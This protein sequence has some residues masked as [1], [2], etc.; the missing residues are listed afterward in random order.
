MLTHKRNALQPRNNARRQ[1]GDSRKQQ[2][3][4]Q[5]GTHMLLRVLIGFLFRQKEEADT[6][7]IAPP[8]QVD[9]QQIEQPQ[10]FPEDQEIPE[11]RT[12]AVQAQRSLENQAEDGKNDGEHH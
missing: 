8:K 10:S 7:C 6:L 5:K 9:H 2:N 1:G 12:A 4:P 3:P 11:R